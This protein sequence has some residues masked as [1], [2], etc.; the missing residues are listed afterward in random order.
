M[1]RRCGSS[2]YVAEMSPVCRVMNKIVAYWMILRPITRAPLFWL[3][4]LYVA[5]GLVYA[6]VTP[7]L[8]KPDEND[9]YG[10]LLYL[11]EH[12]TLPPLSSS[13]KWMREA[14]QPPLYYITAAVLTAWLPDDPD[15]YELL[16]SNPYIS[17]SVPGYRNDNRN[18]YLHPPHMTPLV[19][20]ARLVSLIF[21]LGTMLV[22]Y[23]LAAQIFPR[24]SG[25]PITAAALVGFQ[26]K[27]LYIATAINN[28]AAVTFFGAL[29]VAIIVHR[30]Q[31][32]ESVK[33]RPSGNHPGYPRT[34]QDMR[35]SICLGIVLGLA[36]LTK[37]SSLVF[38]PL[39]GLALLLIHRNLRLALFRD[40]LVIIAIAVLIGG[41]W[42]VRNAILYHDPFTLKILSTFG[43]VGYR[44]FWERLLPDLRSI[45]YTFWANQSRT[46]ISPILPD[47]I[48]IWWGRGSLALLILSCLIN[49]KRIWCNARV[50][51]TLLLWPV[52]FLLLLVGYWTRSSPWPFGRLLFPALTP[53]CV[54][55]VWGWYYSLPESLRRAG[56]MLSMAV[57]IVVSTWLPFVSLYPLFHPSPER[58]AEQVANPVGVVYVSADTNT[59]IARLVGYNLRARYAVPGTYFPLELCWEPLGHTD[60]PYAVLVHFLDL[61]QHNKGREP[62][63]WGSRRTYPGLGSRPTD[64]WPLHRI[65]CDNVLV[66]VHPEVPAPSGAA[67]EVALLNPSTSQRLQVRDA[68]GEPVA[69]AFVG[70]VA[71]L[72]PDEVMVSEQPAL[73]VFDGAIGLTQVQVLHDTESVITLTLTWKSLQPVPYDAMVF[74]HLVGPDH[75]L[76]AQADR[77][78]LDGRFP[79][80]YWQPGQ[81]ITDVLGLPLPPGVDIKDLTLRLGMYRWPS[82][83]RLPVT[84]AAGTPQPDNV[85][86]QDAHRAR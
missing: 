8:E 75:I 36:G 64:R 66:W 79:T 57:V 31:K 27:F 78:P 6:W 59:P 50:W 67:I 14:M 33:E 21:G 23:F 10:Y 58:R 30:L 29:T 3:S 34:C 73:Y 55:F 49:G 80:S 25:A 54:L 20:G 69:L 65:F 24:H 53:I 22:T 48:L 76:L 82:L 46:F 86:V 72:S 43:Y 1:D 71:I 42:Y 68:Q 17:A 26:P 32:G 13:E 28:D 41:W 35:F 85:I 38:F 47:L 15:L 37:V 51:I 77:Q 56:L 63:I 7:V 9:H 40:G 44:G 74:V 19:M 81:T 83:E 16:G 18:Y 12:R 39:V 11:R 2:L 60:V 70:S 4:V 62:A 52:A 61:S 84:D 5:V 45:E